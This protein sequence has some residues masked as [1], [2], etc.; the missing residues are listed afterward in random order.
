MNVRQPRQI[1][2]QVLQRH[3][4][5]SDYIEDILA[6]EFAQHRLATPDR[7]L[8]QEL[9]YG[10]VRRQ[11]TLDWLIARKTPGRT[12]KLTLQILLRL[13]LYQLF[14]LDRIPDH[15]AVNETVDL[16]KQLGFGPQAGFVNA[17]LRGYLREREI[18]EQQLE[19]LR[20]ENPPLA[21]SH[22]EWLFN[23]WETR[24]GRPSAVQLMDWNNQPPPTFA[25]INLLRSEPATL[26]AQWQTEGVA[27]E[28]VHAD[29]APDGTLYRLI[30]HPHLTDLDSF[31]RGF[32]YVQDPSTLL[33]VH[34]LAPKPGEQIQDLCAAPGGKTVF[35]AQQMENRGQLVA[36]DV[37]P[38]RLK[39]VQEN[40]A[41]LGV[42]CVA[43][44]QT[45]DAPVASDSPLFDRILVDAPCSNSG[46]MRRRVDLRWRI[47]P[48]ELVRLQADQIQLLRKAAPQVKPGG[49]LTYSTCSL[50]PEENEEVLRLFL[51]EHSGFQV[52][53][54]R[55]LVP[56][57]EG[58]DGAYVASLTRIT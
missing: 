29:W 51:Q 20:V 21:C 22:P 48:E 58:F 8:V 39:L 35:I 31:K 15:A 13:G 49:T 5:G 23:R 42:T 19:Q 30:S 11:S 1:A 2:V 32:F 4:Q 25:R 53:A 55:Q 17:L 27:F 12:Q 56:F 3:E 36:R 33:A 6:Q 18:T 26:T 41:R 14:Y 52:Q 34:L 47:R 57:K 37:H 54:E 24:W 43:T 40:C 9:T 46:V 45:D 38:D 44:G 16:A 50:E 10:V 7:G 28:P